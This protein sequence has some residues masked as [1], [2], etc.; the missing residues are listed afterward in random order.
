MFRRTD[1]DRQTAVCERVNI[2]NTRTTTH[3]TGQSE[4]GRW[5][6]G[7]DRPTGRIDRH[8]DT[9]S[10]S[11]QRTPHTWVCWRW[12]TMMNDRVCWMQCSH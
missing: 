5:P 10:C 8:Q 1:S 12:Y 3:G 9:D 7:W 6:C 11:V 4:E 2:N